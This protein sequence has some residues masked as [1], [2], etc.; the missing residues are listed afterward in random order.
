MNHPSNARR[1]QVLI[2][3]DDR[4]LVAALT[5][6][7]E[8]LGLDARTSYDGM[9]AV[10]EL[11]I[12]HENPPDLIVLDVN[13][14]C[15][16]G[17]S[18]CESLGDDSLLMPIPVVILTGRD[19][20]ATMRKCQALGAHYLHK[21]SDVW[22]LLRPLLVKLLDLAT[23]QPE[24]PAPGTV[25]AA[26]E[27]APDGRAGPTLLCIDD[28]RDFCQAMSIRLGHLGYRVITAYNGV[29]GFWKALKEQPAAIL[30]DLRMTSGTGEYV[31][32]QILGHAATRHIPVIIVSGRADPE[33]MDRL[34]QSGAAA[35]LTKPIAMPE[36]LHA[37]ERHIGGKAA[38]RAGVACGLE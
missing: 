35:Y 9:A 34:R 33:V 10:Y 5:L 29:V 26:R 2:V 28:D 27:D 30:A 38:E 21:Q 16:D 7:C 19:D 8:S 11:T 22:P 20:E 6:R 1:P 12:A 4:D 14:P 37:L 31:L 23:D 32:R 3:D 25:P 36:L 24:T 13:L 17:L 15:E 18:V